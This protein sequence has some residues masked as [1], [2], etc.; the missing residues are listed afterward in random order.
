[1]IDLHSHILFQIDD[2]ADSIEESLSLIREAVDYGVTD[3]VLTPHFILGSYDT[4]NEEKWKLFSLLKK[5][6]EKENIPIRLY[7]GNEVC[8]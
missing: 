8:F 2:G 6:V 7:L 4:N 5:E 3:I 1:M